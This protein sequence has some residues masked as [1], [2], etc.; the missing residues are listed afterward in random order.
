M[1]LSSGQLSF[2]EIQSEFGGSNPISLSEYYK[3]GAYVPN[4]SSTTTIP[5]SSAISVGNFRSTSISPAFTTFT[6]QSDPGTHGIMQSI[7]ASPSGV[8]MATGFNQPAP[9][10]STPYGASYSRSTDGINWSSPTIIPGV[11]NN[12][13]SNLSNVICRN[14]GLFVAVGA[15]KNALGAITQSSGVSWNAPQEYPNQIF[16]VALNNNTG[17]FVAGI[18]NG[19]MYSTDAYNWGY[20]TSPGAPAGYIISSIACRESDNRWVGVGNMSSRPARTYSTDGYNWATI[21]TAIDLGSSSTMLSVTVSPKTGR[22]VCCGA[23]FTGGTSPVP[24]VGASDDGINWAYSYGMWSGYGSPTDVTCNRAGVYIM[25]GNPS[26][27]IATP[28]W[29]TST[30]GLNWTSPTLLLN[31]VGN[32][33]DLRG[34]AVDNYVNSPTYG[35]FAAVGG[36]IR[37]GSYRHLFAYQS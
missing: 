5:S 18:L 32:S 21:T 36:A 34:V 30:D 27:D 3:S 25:V 6:A 8:W 16:G 10:D 23:L 12:L 37:T 28:W 14:D 9:G 26:N 35:R 22:F 1:P 2:S 13:F 19:F 4:I 31:A 24:L 20:L 11:A 33:S 7:A 29:S 15:M 17:L